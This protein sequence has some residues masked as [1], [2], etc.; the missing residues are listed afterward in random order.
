MLTKTLTAELN[1]YPDTFP[2][3]FDRLV[4]E[5]VLTPEQARQVLD[6]LS[7]QKPPPSAPPHPTPARTPWAARFAEIGAYLGA[8]LVAAAGAVVVAQQWG[9][10]TYAARVG[11]LGLT[12]LVLVLAA[13]GLVMFRGSRTW[14]DLPNGDTLRRLAGTLFTFGAGAAF[15]TVMVAMLS[16]QQAVSEFEAG[17]ATLIAAG[18]AFAILLVARL[19]AVSALAELA[20]FGAMVG[21]VAG[22]L[23][24]TAADN[25]YS[26][27]VMQWTLLATGLI[28]ALVATYTRL[29][30][31][32]TLGTALGLALALFGAATIA[33][34]PWSHRI[35]LLTLVTVTLA[36]YLTRP[37]WPYITAAIIA[38]VILTVTWVGEAV[39]AALALL[40]A[41]VVVLLLA[42]GALY[43]HLHRSQAA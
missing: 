12:T 31:N 42:G 22:V 33:D 32:R 13:T 5:H 43:L 29:L 25:E 6:A 40:S 24:M 34:N 18:T 15:G 17:R 35:A 7:T 27:R 26:A 9:D 38:A 11:V 14:D 3:P 36:V 2:E 19:A 23:A 16:E 1:P 37:N 21:M 10:M 41:G 20:L 28:W 4:S 39:G 8:A 30:R